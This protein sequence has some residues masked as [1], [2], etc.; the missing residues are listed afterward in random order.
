MVLK[1]PILKI[2]GQCSKFMVFMAVSWLKIN[3]WSI[4]GFHGFHGP[5]ATL[6][7]HPRV[8]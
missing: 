8:N 5:V 4:H 2:H 1:G 6:L 7:G 3:S